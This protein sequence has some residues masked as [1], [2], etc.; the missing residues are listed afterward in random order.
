MASIDLKE[1]YLQ[2]PVHPDSRRF[3]RFVAHGRVYQF[4]ALALA[5]PRSAGLHPG[6]GSC[7]RHSPLLGY[8][9]EAIPRRLA[10]PVVLSRR[11]PPRP[12]GGSRPLPRARHCGQPREVSPRTISGGSV[13]R[14]DDR[15]PIFQG[16]SIAGSH[17]QAAVNRR[18]I[19]ILCRSASQYL[20]VAAGNAILPLSSGSR[21]SA[22]G[23]VTPALPPPVL[24][25]R[26]SVCQDSLVSRLPQG[27]QVVV[28]PSPSFL[29]GVSAASLSRSGLMVQR[30]GRGLGSS[31][32]STYRFRPLESGTQCS[33][34][35]RQRASCDSRRSPPLPVVSG[36]RN[37]SVFCDN[38]TAVA[39]LR[40][41]G[42]TRS[43]F[44][45]SLTQGILRW[46]ESLS[47][48]LVPQFIPGSLN[49]LA[50]SLSRPH[51]LPHTEW[52]LHPEDFRS[53][54]RLWPVQI[55]LFATSENHHLFDL[56]LPS[57][58]R[59]L[60]AETRSF[61]VGT[62]FSLRV[63]SMVRHSSCA[64][65]APDF[66]GDGAHLDSSVLASASLVS[67]PPS[68][69][70]GPSGCSSRRPDLLRLTRSYSLYLGLHRLRLHAWKLSG[71]SRE[72][73]DS[74]PL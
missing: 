41:E 3:L 18:R 61:N 40:K 49:V 50:E 46:A 39:Y 26:G 66:S 15:C 48:R 62:V 51:Q 71:A 30:L 67:R 16:L 42:G 29:R 31:P 34:Y 9:H 17:R 59:W 33:L 23:E 57:G 25:S 64:G 12:S 54:S 8:P 47:I 22:S 72:L 4:S 69:V 44:L 52:S 58:I 55:D 70:A 13:S 14:G 74:H 2:V 65:E 60:R 45:N 53:I 68:P 10:R 36:G 27:S 6:H 56:F 43:P 73:Q 35:Q 21:R 32:R 7:F 28:S 24:G 19:S 37:V 1:A 5:S 11:A 63:S 38:T 20:A